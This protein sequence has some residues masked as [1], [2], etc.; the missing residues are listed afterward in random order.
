MWCHLWNA[1]VII[2]LAYQ[3]S[4]MT[5]DVLAPVWRQEICNHHIDLDRSLRITWWRLQMET[6]SPSFV[7]GI[8]R[9]SVNS[10]HKGQWRGALIFSLICT[11][12][13]GWVNNGGAGD[14]RRYRAHYDVT[15]MRGLVP[16][17]ITHIFQ[18]YLYSSTAISGPTGM[19]GCFLSSTLI[20]SFSID[21]V[22]T[23]SVGNEIAHPQ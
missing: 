23:F 11:R 8:H 18:D 13:Y 2:K 5:D 16:V 22:L 7:R 4:M 20:F 1:I 10:P 17:Y 15:V 21:V 19:I 3:V 12:I 9:S 6:F 14:L